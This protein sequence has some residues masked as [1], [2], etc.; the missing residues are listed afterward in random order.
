MGRGRWWRLGVSPLSALLGGLLGLA[1]NAAMSDPPV[2]PPFLA[3]Y[4]PW[5]PGSTVVVLLLATVV[6]A[7]FDGVSPRRLRGCGGW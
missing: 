1:G 6:V 4:V 7:V 3:G 5:G 2:W